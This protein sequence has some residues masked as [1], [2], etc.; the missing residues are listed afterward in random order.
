MNL[1]NLKGI[2]YVEQLKEARSMKTLPQSE[3]E[4]V[5]CQ[6]SHM[7]QSHDWAGMVWMG[8]WSDSIL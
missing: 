2:A 4:Y 1:T 7:S 5:S 8:S 3:T 6:L